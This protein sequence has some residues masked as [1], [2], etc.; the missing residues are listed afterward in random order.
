[1]PKFRFHRGTLEDSMK[2]VWEVET[3]DDILQIFKDEFPMLSHLFNQDT[4]KIKPYGYDTRI[5]WDT[6]IVTIMGLGPVGFTD[7][8]LQ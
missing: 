8:P 5:E 6:Y 4:V 7:G 2:A 1:M 3:I